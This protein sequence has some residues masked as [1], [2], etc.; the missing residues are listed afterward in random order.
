[1]ANKEEDPGVLTVTDHIGRGEFRIAYYFE[2]DSD[3]GAFLGESSTDGKDKAPKKPE[4]W[5]HWRAN[6]VCVDLQAE[7]DNRGFYWHTKA[8]AT[9]ALRQIKEALKHAD[10]PLPE[11]AEKALA[12]GWKPPKG[13]KP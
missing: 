11:W 12:A 2:E 4:E 8:K 1:M 9:A 5:E 3:F 6:K 13:W 10:K 7:Q